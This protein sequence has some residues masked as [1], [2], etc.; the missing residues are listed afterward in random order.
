MASK[1]EFDKHHFQN[2][3]TLGETGYYDL[4]VNLTRLRDAKVLRLLKHISLCI[5][6]MGTHTM[7]EYFLRIS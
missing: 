5:A 2:P 6:Y 1:Q 3:E 7:V 4:C